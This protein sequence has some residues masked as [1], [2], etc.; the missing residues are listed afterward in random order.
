LLTDRSMVGKPSTKPGEYPYM[1]CC[2][3]KAG[4]ADSTL[5]ILCRRSD[6]AFVKE[7]VHAIATI[8]SYTPPDQATTATAA[9]RP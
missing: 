3:L 1:I 8:T 7:M 4:N 9:S 6:D 5:T 2:M